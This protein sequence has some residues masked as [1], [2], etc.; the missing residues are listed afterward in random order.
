[1]EIDT[2]TIAEVTTHATCH[3]TAQW[4]DKSIETDVTSTMGKGP[5]EATEIEMRGTLEEGKRVR[6][7]EEEMI[8]E[9][10]GGESAP[11]MIE[12]SLQ[13]EERRGI[14]LRK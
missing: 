6:T 7:L 11:R 5:M 12:P 8:V 1:M 10:K 4:A 2:E 9:T 3:N 14:E 13:K